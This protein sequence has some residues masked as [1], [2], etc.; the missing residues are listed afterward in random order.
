MKLLNNLIL[1]K[2]CFIVTFA[3]HCFKIGDKVK[4]FW[5][6]VLLCIHGA[7]PVLLIHFQGDDG[8]ALVFAIMFVCMM[9]FAEEITV[10]QKGIHLRNR[11]VE[12]IEIN[13]GYTSVAENEINSLFDIILLFLPFVKY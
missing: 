8:T 12:I 3:Y 6:V 13:N 7:A 10:Q 11:V 1:L 5:H 2:I 4:K 9:F